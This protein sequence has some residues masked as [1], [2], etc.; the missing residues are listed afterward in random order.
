MAAGDD[1]VPGVRVPA[2]RGRSS[3]GR[4]A[5]G[6]WLI[7]LFR[8]VIWAVLLIIGYR[9]VAAIVT[10]PAPA[11][12]AG[13]AAAEPGSLHGFPASLAEAYALQFGIAY[14][15]FSPAAAAQR[16]HQLAAFLPAGSPAQLGWN[17]AGTQRLQ[18]EQV[19][20]VAVQD[21][22]HAVITLLATVNGH[23]LELGVPIYAAGNGLVVSGEPALLPP[24]ARVTPPEPAGPASDP[25]TQAALSSQLPA[26]FQ[27]YGSGDEVTL[28][29]F[30]APGA[31]LT[32]LGGLVRFGS[33]AQLSVPVGGATRHVVVTVVWR[34][35]GQPAGG[36]GAAGVSA[37]SPSLE[38]T[39]QMTVVRRDGSWYV[40]AIGASAQPPGAP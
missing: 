2:D 17:G 13:A 23:L 11:S 8:G 35:P 15:N 21:S 3:P 32:G 5:G 36:R 10:R 20:S 30:L 26:F 38:M 37:A 25:D 22:N 29:R 4:G 33:I 40:R 7:W 31:R 14:L 6:R 19:A 28:G 27:A 24:P 9:G 18:G 16:A 1:A 39:Y 12:P 34:L